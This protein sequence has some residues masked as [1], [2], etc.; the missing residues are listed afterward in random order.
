ML[1][2]KDLCDEIITNVFDNLLH[3]LPSLYT[4][5]SNIYIPEALKSFPFSDNNKH[6]CEMLRKCLTVSSLLR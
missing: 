5:L 1:Q 4:I 6:A 2:I 3:E